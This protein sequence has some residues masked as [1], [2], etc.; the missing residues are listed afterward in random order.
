MVS[1]LH[2]AFLLYRNNKQCS[3]ISHNDDQSLRGNYLQYVY[4]HSYIA[5]YYFMQ[6]V[7]T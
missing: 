7:C 3:N 6:I 5:S 4:T 2:R 1:T